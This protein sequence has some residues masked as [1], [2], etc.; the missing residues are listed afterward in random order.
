MS[1]QA[2]AIGTLRDRATL[3]R[4]DETPGPDGGHETVFVPLA[5]VWARVHARAASR[6]DF[7]DARGAS[8][9]HT[10]VM[11]H[12]TDLVPG[13]RIVSR[14]R[15]LDLL[16]VEDLNGRRAYITCACAETTVTG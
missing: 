3:Y 9:T 5:T 13:D 12:R 1:A 8:A 11:R 10:V 15:A 2:P 6:A 7:A 16:S 4:K 14:G